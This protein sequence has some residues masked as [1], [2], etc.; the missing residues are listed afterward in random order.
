M[1]KETTKITLDI[2]TKKR[3]SLDKIAQAYGK[4]LNMII[5]EAIDNYIRD[6]K[7]QASEVREKAEE[8]EPG[9]FATD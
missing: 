1:A 7:W 2:D 8:A 3:E 9:D 5:T 6:H 4:N